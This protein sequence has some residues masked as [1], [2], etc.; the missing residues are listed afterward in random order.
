[1][2]QINVNNHKTYTIMPGI[3]MGMLTPDDLEKIAAICRK[4]VN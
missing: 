1:M 3:K 2:S 4:F